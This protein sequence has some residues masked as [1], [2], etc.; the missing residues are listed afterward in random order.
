MSFQPANILVKKDY[1]LKLID[2]GCA[3]KI[4]TDNGQLVD[5]IGVTEF[6]GIL[7]HLYNP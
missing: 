1:T 3:R 7:I 5:A 6:A 2:Y 4:S